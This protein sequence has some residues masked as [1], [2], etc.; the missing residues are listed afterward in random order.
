MIRPCQYKAIKTDTI[1]ALEEGVNALIK[2]GW[3][4]HGDT[5]VFVVTGSSPYYF[6]SMCK[7]EAVFMPGEQMP[8]GAAGGLVIPRG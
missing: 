3:T 5:K 8:P 6:Q 7:T 2:E 1:A 4:F